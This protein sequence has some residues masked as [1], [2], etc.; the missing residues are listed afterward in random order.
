MKV[1]IVEDKEEFNNK[2]SKIANRILIEKNYD[3][4]VLSFFD[5]NK[6]LKEVI[7]SKARNIYILDIEL[8]N[9]HGSDIAREIREGAK[10][11]R[12][13]III[14]SA[15]NKKES[16]ISERLSIYTYLLKGEDFEQNLTETI[17]SALD[18]LELEGYLSP[19]NEYKLIHDDI[20]YVKKEKNSKYCNIH[21]LREPI[22]IRKTIK[23]IQQ[24]LKLKKIK[25]SIL[26]NEQNVAYRDEEKIIFKNKEVLMIKE[27]R[28][29]NRR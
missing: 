22:R 16:L 15:H 20:L 14:S 28:K 17:E 9:Y 27:H 12:S 11:W 1:V 8:E 21:T 13:I 4:D 5:Y 19:K 24:E 18:I 29:K 25:K 10:D 7:H 3:S 23:A 2:I 26:V 6:E